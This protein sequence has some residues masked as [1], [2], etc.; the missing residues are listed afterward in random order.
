[1]SDT[2][3]NSATG[4]SGGGG[5]ITS[6]TYANIDALTPSVGDQAYATD[7]PVSAVCFSA[8]TWTYFYQN[9]RLSALPTTGWSWV[10]QGSATVTTNGPFLSLNSP[11]S[12]G[13]DIHGYVRTAPSTPYVVTT[14]LF[15]VDGGTR[16]VGM[17]L[18]ESSTGELYRFGW[19][20]TT[21]EAR[22][23]V[24]RHDN[25]PTVSNAI[26]TNNRRIPANGNV[27]NLVGLQIEDDGTD[28]YFR[29]IMPSGTYE[30]ASEGRTSRMAGGPDQIGLHIA[31]TGETAQLDV[32]SWDEA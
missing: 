11:S 20:N 3:Y 26:I 12:A 8:G 32:L 23:C 28:L 10:N 9:F 24:V 21:S 25:S 22:G 2:T 27:S 19:I 6:D 1:M 13:L 5:S 14:W 29:V 16:T 30:M 7:Y 4:P 15:D 31:T 18:R 17:L